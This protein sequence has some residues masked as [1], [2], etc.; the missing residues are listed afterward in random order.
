MRFPTRR[1]H[2][3]LLA[4]LL[5]SAVSPASRA[6]ASQTATLNVSFNPA[7]LGQSTS[8]AFHIRILASDGVP[9]PLTGLDLHYPSDLGVAISG[10]GLDTCSIPTLENIGPVGCPAEARMGQGS[11]IAE[12]PLGPEVIQE[13]AEVAILRAPEEDGHQ[14]LNFY[15]QGNTPISLPVIFPGLLLAGTT[16]QTETIK[17][18][19]PLVGTVPGA[20]DVS[21]A[22]LNATLGPR[23]LIYYERIDGKFVP[24]RPRGILLPHKCP[25][26]G[27]PFSAILTFVD[28]SSTTATSRIPCQSFPAAPL[29][30][31]SL[32]R[33]PNRRATSKASQHN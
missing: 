19:I 11:A 10:L 6:Y 7:R 27:F 2:R 23:G 9:E 30:H 8:V 13:G 32:A 22:R 17:L 21:V 24:Y 18:L 12:V 5:A 14:G 16:S 20:A 15:V 25:P 29:T 31:Q 33:S 1:A 26:G 28:R 4:L 3:Y